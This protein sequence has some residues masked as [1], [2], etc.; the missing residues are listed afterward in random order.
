MDEL[1]IQAGKFWVASHFRTTMERLAMPQQR[2][3]F[4]EFLRNTLTE[5]RILHYVAC[6]AEITVNL[7][8]MRIMLLPTF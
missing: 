7:I 5:V 3:I 4:S 1:L 6:I 2:I 8:T